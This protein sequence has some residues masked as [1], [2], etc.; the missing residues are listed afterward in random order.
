M[1]PSN[2]KFL[3]GSI[4]AQQWA[5]CLDGARYGNLLRDIWLCGHGVLKSNNELNDTQAPTFQPFKI[6]Y[7]ILRW[8]LSHSPQ[9]FQ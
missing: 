7:L 3:T 6:K 1:L 2:K 4:I 5:K 9:P 8:A